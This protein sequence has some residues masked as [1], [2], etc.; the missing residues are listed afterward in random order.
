MSDLLFNFFLNKIWR[1]ELSKKLTKDFYGA[2][3]GLLKK[4]TLKS[5]HNQVLFERI[6]RSQIVVEIVVYFNKVS[7]D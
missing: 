7:N 1:F 5:L 4:I 3:R 2:T 6:L